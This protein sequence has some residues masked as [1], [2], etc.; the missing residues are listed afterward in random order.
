MVDQ[1]ASIVGGQA[2]LIG[3]AG[4]LLVGQL[5][6]LG[7]DAFDELVGKV[8]GR[9]VGLGEQAVVVSGFLH[10]HDDGVLHG[11]VPM[12]GFLV[13]LT[14]LF[15]NLGLTA[16]LISQAV[17]Q[18]LEGV[19]VL[20]LGLHAQLRGAA[21]T[22]A[23]VAV[24][25]HG[26]FLH[27]AVGDADGQIDLT[28]LLH[29][30]ARLFRRAQIRF[31]DQLDERRAGAVV[32]HQRVRSA[33]DTA[34]VAADVDHLAGVFL[35]MDAR[36][37]HVRRVAGIGDGDV[38]A[39]LARLQAGDVAALF[40]CRAVNVQIKMAAHAERHRTLRGLEV[41]GHVRVHV[42]LAV[43]H[44]VLLDVAVR[45]QASK[46]DGLNSGLVRHGQSAR[47]AQ[48]HRAGV[49]VRV[50]AELKLAAA[51]HLRV[52]RGQ[53]GMDLQADDRFPILQ[54]FFELTHYSTTFPSA[55]FGATG[56][57]P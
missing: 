28:Q 12:A 57:L 19:H 9:Q 55:K 3:E 35:H 14:A 56:A 17:M 47:K 7:A 36:D 53:L 21:A 33:R 45:G 48:A 37:A 32:V 11:G 31:G 8:V 46:H 26:A 13:D 23:D 41:L 50:G 1:V 49:R 20:Q 38:L 4:G 24:A 2:E 42:V 10:A 39:R 29:E 16:D 43:E 30:Q 40:G 18:V 15:Q 22:Q 27:G 34:L 52:Q 5:G 6:Q 54:H 51:E 25:A 44:A